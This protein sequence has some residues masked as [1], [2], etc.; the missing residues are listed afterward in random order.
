MPLGLQTNV[1]VLPIDGRLLRRP[2]A[3]IPSREVRIEA[4]RMAKAETRSRRADDLR[5]SQQM[6]AAQ[7]GDRAAYEA[8]LRDC[9]PLIKVF[10][11]RQGV[12]PDHVDDVVQDVLLTIH[13]ARQTYDPARPFTAWLR[14]I[15]E[16]RA[17]D[18][19]RRRGR[20]H[21]REVH[22]PHAA[23]TYVDET[24]ELAYR[25]EN[26]AASN[27]IKRALEILPERQREAVQVLVIEEQSLAEAAITTRRSKGALKVNL[28]R[29][30]KAL[31]AKLTGES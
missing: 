5:R 2:F 31:R 23:E 6:A 19:L 16:R 30:L 17:I 3:A 27:R 7:G 14:V 18:L 10:A 9:V 11:G 8:L 20:Q 1:M 21:V 28:H 12:P 24:A 15:A 22:A 29:A 13:S 25:R 26:S 4:G